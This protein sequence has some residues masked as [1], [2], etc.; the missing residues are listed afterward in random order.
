MKKKAAWIV[1]IFIILILGAGLAYRL[2]HIANPP[3]HIAVFV[4]G[5]E[6]NLTA[7]E[8]TLI[9]IQMYLEEINAKG[10]INGHPHSSWL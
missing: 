10:G 1:A 8:N 2:I 9:P 5:D 3:I 4:P 6:D 7:T